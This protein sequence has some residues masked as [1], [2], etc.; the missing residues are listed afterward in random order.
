MCT[1]HDRSGRT[2]F[3]DHGADAAD[4]GPGESRAVGPGRRTLLTAAG[5]GGAGLLFS[6]ITSPAD[7]AGRAR[8]GRLRSRRRA[9]VIVL[10][11]CRPDEITSTL[12]PTTARLQRNGHRFPRARSM[13]VM[14]TIPNHV[15]MMTGVRPD[16]NGVPANA[17][18][19]RDEGVVR[20]LDRPSDLRF[21]TLLQR[22]NRRGYTTGTVLSKD[23][24]YGIFGTRATH[25][26][27]PAP[28]IPVSGH[29]P[30]N[31]TMDATLAMIEEFDPHLVFVNLGNIDR[32]G[33]TDFTGTSLRLARQAALLT[34]DMQV[35]RLER[36][37]KGS[38][39]WDDSLLLFLADH[40]MDWSLPN[41]VITLTDDV[42]ADP[43]LAG[44]T[45]VAQNG[46]AD[47]V[48]WT[49]PENA[50]ARAVRRIIALAEAQ[51]G[52]LRAHDIRAEQR[53]LH[54][55]ERGGD[56]LVYCKAG[57]RFSDPDPFANPI[58]GNHGHPATRP[59]PFFLSG[60]HPAVP[61]RRTTSR[62]VRT[63]DVAPTVGDFFGMG[64]PRGGYDGTSRL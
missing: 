44:R 12:M 10:D 23:Y 56:V 37:L 46:G 19:D 1:H 59:I 36:E 55:G 63:I 40:S 60:G 51:E 7:A 32:L 18:Y 54:L 53:R 3:T 57:W 47:L 41:K 62:L 16:R 15:M 48:T 39:R 43:F 27:E 38:G 35:A 9:Y 28:I 25:R 30:D 64:A 49:G 13:P 45:V 26:W 58:P 6:S 8:A 34:T 50:R 33:H 5:A 20:E 11:G 17:I 2:C 61:R 29:A 14:E 52:V 31:F 21:P 4:L 24:L 22:M 42:E